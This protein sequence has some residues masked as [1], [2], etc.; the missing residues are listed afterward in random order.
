[1]AEATVCYKSGPLQVKGPST[2]EFEGYCLRFEGPPDLAG[3]IISHGAISNL[4]EFKRK[5]YVLHNHRS[6]A[7]PIATLLD[8]KETGDGLYVKGRFTGSSFAQEIR[9]SMAERQAVGQC[10][11]EMSIGYR[12][13][14]HSYDNSKKAR[15]LDRIGLHECSVLTGVVACNPGAEIFNV[16]SGGTM[17]AALQPRP[18]ASRSWGLTPGQEFIQS[19]EYKNRKMFTCAVEVK[20]SFIDL[21]SVGTAPLV[22][23]P[24]RP[25]TIVDLISEIAVSD[26]SI[27]SASFTLSGD[28]ASPVSSG[29]LKAPIAATVTSSVVPIETVPTWV[30]VTRAAIEDAEQLRTAI[31]TALAAAIRRCEQAQIL[32]GTGVSPQLRGILSDPGVQAITSTT[33]PAA[34]LEGQ[35]LIAE[36]GLQADA[37]VISPSAW[38]SWRLSATG[39]RGFDPISQTVFGMVPV[40]TTSIA[41]TTVLVGSFRASDVLYR[42]NGVRIIL[43][44]EGSDL[45]ANRILILAESRVAN[46]VVVP[47]GFARG[48]LA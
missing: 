2:G 17:S 9:L 11:G 1:M 47:A 4:D 48:T 43:G 34:V 33:L 16:K 31:D 29:G 41:S 18:L 44:V 15:R 14:R 24:S 6:E 30:K 46:S 21:V 19:S 38:E 27:T 23:L 35:R 37:F 40:V 13:L 10:P 39:D 22:S 28:I 8:V 32:N 26:S 7:P 36:A 5:G 42:K 20:Q 45:I 25:V 3:E 12:V